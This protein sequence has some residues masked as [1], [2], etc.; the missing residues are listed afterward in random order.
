MRR[1]DRVEGRFGLRLPD[2]VFD[3]LPLATTSW[4]LFMLAV[5]AVGGWYVAWF[6][7]YLERHY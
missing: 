5:A 4:G 3:A 1:L 7:G 2:Q 6:V